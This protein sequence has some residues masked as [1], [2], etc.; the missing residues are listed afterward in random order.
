[1][2]GSMRPSPGAARR[3]RLDA[4]MPAADAQLHLDADVPVEV[5]RSGA[6]RLA[7]RGATVV[8]L[9]S[10]KVR[11]QAI[12]FVERQL[13]RQGITG[14]TASLDLTVTGDIAHPDARGAFDVRDVMYRNIAGLGRDS[15]L[16]TVPGLGRLARD[17]HPPGQHQA[18]ARA[19]S[20]ATRGVLDAE[21]QTPVDLGKIIAGADPTTLPVRASVN[22]PRFRLA[23]LADFTDGFK[24]VQGELYGRIDLSGTLQR[25]SGRAASRHRRRPGRQGAVPAGEA[26]RRGRQ[27]AA[28]RPPRHATDDRRPTGWLPDRRA[29]PRRSAARLPHRQGSG[30]RLRAPV[31]DERPRARG[32]RP[33]VRD[34][35]GQRR[36]AQGA[37]V[38]GRRQ[39]TRRRDRTADVSRR[40]RERHARTRTGR[41]SPHRDA[42]RRRNAST[43]RDGLC[44]GDRTGCRRGRRCSPRTPTASW[45]PRRAAPAPASTATWR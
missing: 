24:G 19:S 27:G 8:H 43:G 7:S 1:M 23:S 26:R 15:T 29:G 13:A 5:A 42:L 21:L 30:R 16:K 33:A 25:P 6:P 2:R 41:P 20:F 44:W 36:G 37:G 32:H 11:L 40:A 34:G 10:N 35:R 17:R 4:T 39:G 45:S 14:G 22:I 9:K 38:A 12:P 18:R 28:R 3:S 31:P